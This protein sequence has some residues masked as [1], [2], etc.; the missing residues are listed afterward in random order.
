[1][2]FTSRLCV[3]A[4]IVAAVF[5]AWLWSDAIDSSRDATQL[6]VQQFQNSDSVAANLREASASQNWWPF[7]WPAVLIVI[8]LAMF[9]DDLE[10]WW[11]QKQE[12]A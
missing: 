9:W 3:F 2:S 12:N 1:M 6:A 8:A 10:R 4:L 7:L 5:I 11:K